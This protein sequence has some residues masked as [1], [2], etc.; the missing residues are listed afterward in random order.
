MSRRVMR[1]HQGENRVNPLIVG[2]VSKGVITPSTVGSKNLAMT[3]VFITPGGE[4]KSHRHIQEEIYYVL[5]GAGDLW[6]DREH[7]KLEKGLFVYL[8][9][10]AEHAIKNMNDETL[11]LLVALSPP[12]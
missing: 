3:Q 1:V 8:P 10:N 7:I 4:L 6:L 11:V 5:S 12:P 2:G 9:S